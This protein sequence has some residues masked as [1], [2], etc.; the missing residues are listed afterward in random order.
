[1][2]DDRRGIFFLWP[3]VAKDDR[4]DG[5]SEHDPD[6]TVADLIEIGGGCEALENGELKGKGH[7][8][9]G[10]GNAR[11]ACGDPTRER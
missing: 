10:V 2:R 8:Q 4:D 11:A 6:N 1:M 9:P 5:D 3:E 7:L